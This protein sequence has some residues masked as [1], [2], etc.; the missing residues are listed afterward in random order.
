MPECHHQLI[1]ARALQNPKLD[2]GRYVVL[3]LLPLASLHRISAGPNCVTQRS[4]CPISGG[5]NVKLKTPRV[6]HTNTH[7][8]TSTSGYV[9]E[10]S[11]KNAR[12]SCVGSFLE[13]SSSTHFLSPSPRRSGTHTHTATK[14]LLRKRSPPPPP[15]L[16][17]W[18]PTK[19][20]PRW[21]HRTTSNT[22]PSARQLLRASAASRTDLTTPRRRGP[23]RLF[24]ACLSH[25]SN[26]SELGICVF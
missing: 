4:Q 10:F 17:P 9:L 12:A 16:H 24:G 15:F 13:K 25:L 19:T 5:Q 2:S 11:N 14:R 20:S 22:V 8:V 26:F 18:C 3:L 21:S 1:Q 23:L 7:A 6:T